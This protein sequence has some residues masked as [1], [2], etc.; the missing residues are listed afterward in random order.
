MGKKI[1]VRLNKMLFWYGLGND[2][3]WSTTFIVAHGGLWLAHQNPSSMRIGRGH[4][5]A[6]L[7]RSAA[8]RTEWAWARRCSVQ[9]H[10]NCSSKTWFCPKDLEAAHR[11][12]AVLQSEYTEQNN[13]ALRLTSWSM[14]AREWNSVSV[15][16]VQR[17]RNIV[18]VSRI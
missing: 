10:Y 6:G 12:N 1:A 3:L 5:E 7:E 11:L 16:A 17:R 8:A 4:T 14:K 9:R 13:I 18:A 15:Q 2:E